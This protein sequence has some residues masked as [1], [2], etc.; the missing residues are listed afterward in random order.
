LREELEARGW[1]Q[2][3]LA[4]ILGRP[5]RLVSE[6]I[7]GKRSITPETARGLA[8]ALKTSPQF[9]MNLESAYQ[10]SRVRQDDSGVAKRARLFEKAPIKEMVRRN[11]IEASTSPEVLESSLLALYGVESLDHEPQIWHAARK[12]SSYEHVTPA[13]WAWLC[14]ARQLTQAMDTPPYSEARF[15]ELIEQL[16]LLLAS[17]DDVRQAPGT[18]AEYGVR[19]V[20]VEPLAGTRIDGACFWLNATAPVAVVSIRFDR[21][22]AFWFTLLHELGH[23]RAKDGL[24]N[25]ALPIDV[26]LVGQG[27]ARN[28]GRPENELKADQFAMQCIIDPAR[29]DSF[30]AR[31]RPLYSKEKIRSFAAM[32]KVHPGL[33]VGQLQH[34]GEISYAHNRDMLTKVRDIVT[35]AA[36]TDG[37]GSTPARR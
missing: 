29:L 22:D 13:Q 28:E 19:L 23:V 11:W 34:R 24:K 8:E 9:W 1:T 17:P 30:V 10:L 25:D 5:P 16:R 12:S 26:D 15:E 32:N 6:I 2:A 37:W 20:V 14:R 27:T 3:D 18:L 31:T 33:V 21:L 4:E 7:G 35:R 36:I